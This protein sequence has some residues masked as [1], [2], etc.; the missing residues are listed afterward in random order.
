MSSSFIPALSPLSCPAVRLYFA[1]TDDEPKQAL[2]DILANPIV[3]LHHAT[4]RPARHR[5][6][7]KGHVIFHTEFDW[8]RRLVDSAAV[9]R[10]VKRSIA[11]QFA[12]PLAGLRN[13]REEN[14]KDP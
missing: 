6:A 4:L 7:R 13:S 2:R 11:L 9:L 3:P 1:S 12:R 5:V 8:L 14:K 10:K